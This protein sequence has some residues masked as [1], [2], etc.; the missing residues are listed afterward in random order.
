MTEGEPLNRLFLIFAL[1]ATVPL[2]VAADD[3]A[4]ARMAL[5]TAIAGERVIVVIVRQNFR[6][7]TR[8]TVGIPGI[9]C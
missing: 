5:R 6:A 9:D 3:N 7:Y 2:S 4:E 1:L 8:L